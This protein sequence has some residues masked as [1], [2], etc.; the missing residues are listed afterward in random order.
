MVGRV[1]PLSE[2]R[3]ECETDVRLR[4]ETPL[5]HAPCLSRCETARRRCRGGA[6]AWRIFRQKSQLNVPCYGS[7]WSMVQG[8]LARRVYSVYVYY[9]TCGLC[10]L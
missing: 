9:A 7:P 1:R 8:R 10:N 6:G 3:E 5:E 4:V 2:R